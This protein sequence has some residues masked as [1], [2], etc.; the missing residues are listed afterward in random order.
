MKSRK[1]RVGMIGAGGI[2]RIHCEGWTQLK[3]CELV[4]ITDLSLEAAA[5]RAEQF[6]IPSVEPTGRKLLARKDID[7]VD[8]VTPNMFH[9][10]YTVA[11]LRAGKHVLCEK[12]LALSTREVDTM[13]S[14]AAKARRKLM[15][16]QH[17]RFIDSSVSLKGYLKRRSL[18]EIYYARAWFNRRR[19]LPTRAGF[20]YKRNSGGGPC[21]DVGVHM[22]DLALHMM[23]NFKPTSVCG[24]S[25]NKLAKRKDSWSEWDWG[26]FDKKGMDVEDFAAGM[27]RFANGAAL[28][29]ECSWMLNQK[30]RSDQ[31]IDLFGTRAGAKWPDCEIYDHTDNDYADT[32]IEVR[33]TGTEP[34]CEAIRAF[35]EAV[36]GNRAVPVQP[37]QTRA[38]IAILAGLYKSQETG[39]EVKL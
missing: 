11:A 17:M 29:L 3:G 13:M 31:R 30:A 39:R 24:V 1:L 34:H 2:S 26:L 20:I 22:L 6:S 4:A 32:K 15:C 19:Q 16:A 8:V 28:T 5:D 7:V 38:V 21:I 12:P 10:Q 18:G 25:M 36:A 33:K 23:G 35:A 27:I 14:A 9:K 37:E